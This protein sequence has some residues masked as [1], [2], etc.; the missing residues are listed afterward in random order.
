MNSPSDDMAIVP[1][2]GQEFVD[3]GLT[4]VAIETGG[5]AVLVLSLDAVGGLGAFLSHNADRLHVI[6]PADH[7]E[8]PWTI[9]LLGIWIPNIAY[10]GLNQFIAQRALAAKSLRDGQL[11]VLFAATPSADV[12]EVPEH[13][14]QRT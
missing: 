3:G 6:L 4:P 14:L 13:E 8:L 1:F 7:P 10:W 2:D 9:Y 11:G 5:A 12:I